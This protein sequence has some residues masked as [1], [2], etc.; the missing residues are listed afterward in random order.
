MVFG[1]YAYTREEKGLK[2]E[3]L[4]F[5]SVE[6][7]QLA[8]DNKEVEYNSIVGISAEAFA[9]DNLEEGKILLTTP[10]KI[11][12]NSVLPVDLDYVNNSDFT[13]EDSDYVSKDIEKEIKD[14]KSP[15]GFAKG[16]LSGIISRLHK[17]YQVEEIGKYIDNI[18][19]LGF[20]YA[21][22]AAGTISALDLPKYDSKHEYIKAAEKT[23][24]L[25]KKQYEKGL[26]TDD[27]RYVNVIKT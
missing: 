3:G 13:I 16:V 18:K 6:E 27:E 12:L 19:S 15:G 5:S 9:K 24:A 25:I 20:K 2:G 22:L 4:I 26:L 8:L 1:L 21:T 11:I 10:G 23:V 17:N 7:V 14:R